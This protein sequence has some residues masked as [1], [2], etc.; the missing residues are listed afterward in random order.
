MGTLHTGDGRIFYT[1]T[2]TI[3]SVEPVR[4]TMGDL[5]TFGIPA[6]EM[7]VPKIKKVIISYPAIIVF[8]DDKTK[9]VVKCQENDIFDPEKGIAIAVM[10]KLYPKKYG[11]ILSGNEKT[12]EYVEYS[13][14]TYMVDGKSY[15]RIKK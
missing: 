1:E 15:H 8:F 13:C 4:L 9:V 12:I 10:R 11:N 5:N 3:A 14:P 2:G 7:L 6:G